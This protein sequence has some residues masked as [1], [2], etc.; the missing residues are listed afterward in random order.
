MELIQNADDNSYPPNTEPSLEFTLQSGSL[1]IDCNERGFQPNNVESICKAGF[2]TKA[3][4]ADGS[5]HYVGEKGIGFKSVFRVASVVWIL[6]GPYS[7]KFDKNTT[8]G[9]VAPIWDENFP[10]SKRSGYTS[11]FLQLEPTCDVETLATD[12]I[13]LDRSVIFLRKLQRIKVKLHHTPR[14]RICDI[15]IG[16]AHV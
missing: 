5:A 15:Q 10:G 16:R 14:R 9:M 4:K 12:L 6:S 13:A 7:F 3:G 8:L 2:S 1:Q 11:F